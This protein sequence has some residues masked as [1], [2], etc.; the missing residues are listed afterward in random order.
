MHSTTSWADLDLSSLKRVGTEFHGPCPV[1][2]EG[3]DCFWVNPERSLVGCRRCGD[4]SGKLDGKQFK[5]HLE[6]LGAAFGEQEGIWSYDWT[7]LS[8]GAMVT[9]TR[10]VGEPKYRWPPR[11]K[12]KNLLYL[13]ARHDPESNRPIVWCEGAKAATAA[14]DK[15]PND[16]YDVIG[17]VGTANI[18]DDEFLEK[19]TIGR[20]CIV[21]PDDDEPGARISNKLVV[22]LSRSSADV[23]TVD[24]AQLDI[25]GG[26]GHDA[27]Q[28]RPGD[29]P[30]A[31]FEAASGTVTPE[32]DAPLT[33]G[34]AEWLAMM[35]QP[36]DVELAPDAP[37]LLYPR[38]IGIVHS[39]RGVGKSTYAAWCAAEASHGGK[40]LVVCC[41]DPASWASRLESFDAMNVVI[42]TMDKL[43]PEGRLE[44]ATHDCHAVII[45][46]WRR[47]LRTADRK[48]GGRPNGANDE[49][50]VGPVIDRLANIAHS[51]GGPAVLMLA[52]EAKSAEATTSRGSVALEDAVDFVRRISKENDVTSIYTA[53]KA[54]VGIPTGPWR[55][56]LQEPG[57]FKPS[58]GGGGGSSSGGDPFKP[59]EG[60]DEQITSYLMMHPGSSAR[61]VTRHVKRRPDDVAAR[62]KVVG[63]LGTD[64]T[65]RVFPVS[66]PGGGETPGNTVS[67]SDT[68]S[69]SH[70]IRKHPETPGN[71]VSQSVSHLPPPY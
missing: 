33:V 48:Q 68:Q 54:R 11:T 35:R 20:P 41:D 65:W 30:S 17:F 61:A 36:P 13:G 40:V 24:P 38:R 22:S 6:A 12:T 2:N 59:F 25:T 34:L 44:R 51:P 71:T 1:T 5:D 42:G 7:D 28:W 27:E 19:L 31:A 66:V 47:W 29:D 49:S 69:V 45:D 58:S 52:N 3:K 43:A 70:P 63:T 23:R 37:G 46:S 21:W 57:G 62:L 60:L 16:D 39:N 50:V 10:H 14:A 53:D 9:Q 56:R 15:L 8:T 18:P 67:Q 4:T 55:M 26:L 64:K 32:D